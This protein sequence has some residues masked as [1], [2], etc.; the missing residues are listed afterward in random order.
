MKLQVK[1]ILFGLLS[2]FLLLYVLLLSYQ[3]NVEL[4]DQN[5][6]SMIPASPPNITSMDLDVIKDEINVF[7]PSIGNYTRL[8]D[9]EESSDADLSQHSNDSA[10]PTYW[11]LQVGPLINEDAKRMANQLRASGFK[12]SLKKH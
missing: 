2:L 6:N 3:S 10:L 9:N 11:Q 12:S 5:R 4:D 8:L 7:T 1:D